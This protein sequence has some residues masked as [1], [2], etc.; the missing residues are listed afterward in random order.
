MGWKSLR[1]RKEGKAKAGDAE[2]MW[3]ARKQEGK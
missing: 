1:H 3:T 2:H